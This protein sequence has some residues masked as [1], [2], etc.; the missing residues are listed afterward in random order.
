MEIILLLVLA[1]LLF[2]ADKLPEMARKAGAGMKEF[3]DA[4]GGMGDVRS[5]LDTVNEIRSLSPTSY[6]TGQILGT[7]EKTAAAETGLPSPFTTETA[8]AAQPAATPPVP[9]P[10]APAPAAEAAPAAPAPVEPTD[11]A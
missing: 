3:K 9:P 6:V 7:T 11:P 1:V 2:G 10:A 8:T 4:V 5:T